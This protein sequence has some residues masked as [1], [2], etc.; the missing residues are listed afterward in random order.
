ML[1][2]DLYDAFN[3]IGFENKTKIKDVGIKFRDTFLAKGSSV[4]SNEL[5]R[6]FRGRNPSMD[7]FLK[8]YMQQNKS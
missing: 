1:A 8:R 5:F 2:T 6:Q 3:D 7:P 4:D